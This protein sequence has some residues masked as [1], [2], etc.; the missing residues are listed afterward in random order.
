VSPAEENAVPRPPDT[1]WY[2]EVFDGAGWLRDSRSFNDRE[3]AVERL[4]SQQRVAPAW[5][6]GTPVQRRLIRETTTYTIE[7]TK[8]QP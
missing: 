7:P 2:V 6:D 3:F 1:S 8:G 5:A 4:T